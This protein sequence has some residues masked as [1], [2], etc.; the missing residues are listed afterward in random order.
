MPCLASPPV[1][2]ALESTARSAAR[3][4]RFSAGSALPTMIS[5]LAAFCCRFFATSSTTPLRECSAGHS[6][7]SLGK[8]HWLSFDA[9]GGGGGGFSTVTCV[10][11]CA[12]R[13][14]ASVAV[15]FTVMAPGAAPVVFTVAVLSLPLMV[16]AELVQFD[17]VT[18]TLSG[19]LALQ[20][21]V[22][23]LPACTVDGLAEQL[24]VGGFFGGSGFTV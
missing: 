24:I 22:D 8:S 15:A 14:G 6:C 20:V 21:I 17:T 18:G 12:V 1:R 11:P 16:P 9:W 19:L 2:Y 7:F 4:L 5:W 10:E 23:V 13:P 3:F